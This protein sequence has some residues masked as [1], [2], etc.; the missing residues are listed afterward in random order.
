MKYFAYGSNMNQKQMKYKGK[1]I[2][3]A[4]KC[5]AKLMNYILKFNKQAKGYPG[6]GYANI[7]PS[8]DSLVEGILYEITEDDFLILDLKEGIRCNPPHYT[9]EPIK[10]KLNDNSET[11]AETYIANQTNDSLRPTK[12][13]LEHLLKAKDSLSTEYYSWL[14]SIETLEMKWWAALSY[15][16]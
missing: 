16:T 2:V 1:I 6:C 3:P 13:Y 14:E 12:E 8:K 11:E 7:V 4:K 10:I 9:K 15:C 5:S